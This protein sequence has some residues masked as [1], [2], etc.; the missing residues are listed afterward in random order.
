MESLHLGDERMEEEEL[1]ECLESLLGISEEGG[2]W[3]KRPDG[4]G[5]KRGKE[6][7]EVKGERVSGIG[8]D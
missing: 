4:K 8:V 5:L 6:V 2:K 7:E 3:E 1:T